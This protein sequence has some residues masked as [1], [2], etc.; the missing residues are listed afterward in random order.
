ML[1]S[2]YI[3]S[4]QAGEKRVPVTVRVHHHDELLPSLYVY[5]VP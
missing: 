2:R 3:P 1:L 5:N 4:S